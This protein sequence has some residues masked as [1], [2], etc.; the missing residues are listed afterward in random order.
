MIQDQRMIDK[1]ALGRLEN[2]LK[3]GLQK[4]EHADFIEHVVPLLVAD[5]KK[6]IKSQ[7]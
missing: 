6:H 7:P 4:W 2:R 3:R 5:L 1:E